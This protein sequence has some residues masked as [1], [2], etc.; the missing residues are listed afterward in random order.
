MM[1]A[2]GFRTKD[3]MRFESWPD[4]R[5]SRQQGETEISRLSATSQRLVE[6]SGLARLEVSERFRSQR[7]QDML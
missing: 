1:D 3:G 7:L 6:W 2:P 4:V 5:E